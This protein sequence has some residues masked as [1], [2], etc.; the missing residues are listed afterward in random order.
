MIR[1]AGIAIKSAQELVKV[2]KTS[3]DTALFGFLLNRIFSA[4]SYGASIEKGELYEVGMFSVNGSKSWVILVKKRARSLASDASVDPGEIW[5][6][7]HGDGL[8]GIAI[9]LSIL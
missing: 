2:G 8:S 4:T 1:V 9:S 7:D 3:P 6:I 5:L